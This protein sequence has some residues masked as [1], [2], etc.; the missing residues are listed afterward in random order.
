MRFVPRGHVLL[1][2][3]LHEL[4]VDLVDVLEAHDDCIG[5]PLRFGRRLVAQPEDAHADPRSS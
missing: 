2:G 1:P 5:D 3:Q 4:G